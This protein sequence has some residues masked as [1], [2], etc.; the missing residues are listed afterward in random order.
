MFDLG[1]LNNIARFYSYALSGAYNIRNLDK[2]KE[3]ISVNQKLL[4]SV[5]KI[6][7]KL[8]FGLLLLSVLIVGTVGTYLVLDFID[9]SQLDQL[10][11]WLFHVLAMCLWIYGNKDLSLLIGYN[12]IALLRRWDTLL[13]LVQIIFSLG[14]LLLFNNIWY[15]LI[16][17]YS[18]HM[19]I[20]YR[21]AKLSH[22]YQIRIY[23]STSPKVDLYVFRIIWPR[24]LKSFFSGLLS[25]G[26]A[27]IMAIFYANIS[28]AK[29]SSS[30][31]LALRIADQIKQI[32]RAPFY[33]KVPKFAQSVVK[34]RASMFGDIRRSMTLSYGVLLITVL[35]VYLFSAPILELISSSTKFVSRDLWLIIGFSILIERFTS[36]HNQMV[37]F[38]RNMVLSHKALLI[39]SL[40]NLVLVIL[41]FDKLGVYI[42]PIGLTMGYLSFYSWY[43]AY[44]NYRFFN[45]S[46]FR[47]EKFHFVP[48][49]VLMIVL[50]AFELLNTLL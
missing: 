21:N 14:L 13:S 26:L 30:Y 39:S 5:H 36:M 24:A 16:N 19:V 34:D 46:F 25:M 23:E 35:L 18:W 40:V 38:T 3:T 31:M 20:V 2:N 11:A 12:K 28:D 49:V 8:Y 6:S 9:F 15:L 37:L 48:V 1:F 4:N 7:A 27:Q 17:Y 45:S 29:S 22:K 41:F 32:S 10:I 50:L 44:R 47:F 33:S 43:V 42:F